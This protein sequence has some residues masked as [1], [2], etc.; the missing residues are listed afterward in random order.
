MGVNTT[1]EEFR[2]ELGRPLRSIPKEE[3][4]RVFLRWQ[5]FFE[6]CIRNGGTFVK[7]T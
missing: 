6:K 4:T 3:F 1:P 7:K 5:E 2:N